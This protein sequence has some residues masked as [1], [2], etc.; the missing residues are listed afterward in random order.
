MVEVLRDSALH[1]AQ[2]AQRAGLGSS[3]IGRKRRGCDVV[4]LVSAQELYV[5][6]VWTIAAKPFPVSVQDD[7]RYVRKIRLST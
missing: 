5:Y 1:G 6:L 4:W 2:N 7:V 3:G